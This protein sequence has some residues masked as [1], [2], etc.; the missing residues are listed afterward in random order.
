MKPTKRAGFSLIEVV[1]ALAV[2]SIGVLGFSQALLGS[3]VLGQVN[4]QSSMARR[5]ASDILE[6]MHTV[7]FTEIFARYNASDLDDLPSGTHMPGTFSVEG[8]DPV[9]T[10]ADGLVG[11]IVFPTVIGAGGGLE[12]REDAAQGGLGLPKDLNL[13]GLIDGLD[14]ALDYKLLPVLVR[15]SWRGIKGPASIEF[16]TTLVDL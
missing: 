3:I 5:A 10:D 12:L 16:K 15:V 11:E 7:P 6:D 14:H 4:H 8:L 13:D 9:A 1:V 2:A